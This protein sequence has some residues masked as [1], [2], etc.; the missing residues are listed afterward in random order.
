MEAKKTITIIK[1]AKNHT[2][3]NEWDVDMELKQKSLN[4]MN[5]IQI[6]DKDYEMVN[7][8]DI[9]VLLGMNLPVNP[10]DG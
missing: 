8:D 4:Q 3:K 7:D 9:V 5:D 2:K 6:E 1:R 10:S